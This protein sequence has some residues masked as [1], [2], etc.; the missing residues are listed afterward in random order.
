MCMYCWWDWTV[1]V[2]FI[3]ASDGF[4]LPARIRLMWIVMCCVT[5]GSKGISMSQHIILHYMKWGMRVS[6]ENVLICYVAIQKYFVKRSHRI[7]IIL[8]LLTRCTL[9]W[10]NMSSLWFLPWHQQPNPCLS[11]LLAQL[12]SRCLPRHQH[13]Y[14]NCQ[15]NSCP[16][17]R[18]WA[19]MWW[20]L[21]SVATN[22]LQ[23]NP[24]LMFLSLRVAPV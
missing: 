1:L 10:S 5:L 11:S 8:V 14:S 12:L 23:W 2:C 20:V 13:Q 3:S 6:F 18:T 19:M 7:L 21:L 15:K 22:W 9:C 17:W 16:I 24:H 4:L